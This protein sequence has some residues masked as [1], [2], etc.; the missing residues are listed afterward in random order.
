MNDK[1][2]KPSFWQVIVSVCAALFG[3]QNDNNRLR[4]FSQGSFAYFAIA[5]VVLVTIFVIALIV[6]VNLVLN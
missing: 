5:G 4:D 2:Q 1:L 3:V 6:I